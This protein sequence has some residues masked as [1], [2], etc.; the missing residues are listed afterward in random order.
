[1]TNLAFKIIHET[2]KRRLP[3]LLVRWLGPR[4]TRDSELVECLP[5]P[6]YVARTSGKVC[7]ED[8]KYPHVAHSGIQ[9]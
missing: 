6:Q 4:K 3:P 9:L 2:K 1:M 8:I 5:T 7:L